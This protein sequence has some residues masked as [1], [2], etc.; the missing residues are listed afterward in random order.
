ETTEL[1]CE[2]QAIMEEKLLPACGAMEAALERLE[3]GDYDEL[4]RSKKLQ[5]PVAQVLSTLGFVAY[6]QQ[7][8]EHTTW[9]PKVH[10]DLADKLKSLDKDAG[11]LDDKVFQRLERTTLRIP[12]FP[13]RVWPPVSGAAAGS[14]SI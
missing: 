11:A 8:A 3:H 12:S 10:W 4:W 9:L 2:L 6:G 1:Q 13:P 7:T 5:E 14:R